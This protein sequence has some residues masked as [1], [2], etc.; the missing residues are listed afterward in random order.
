[1]VLVTP[2][3]TKLSRIMARSTHHAAGYRREDS[4]E[5]VRSLARVISRQHRLPDA[6]PI[7]TT[8]QCDSVGETAPVLRPSGHCETLLD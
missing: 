5:M 6:S 1:M 8:F 4:T 3:Q 2:G 7:V